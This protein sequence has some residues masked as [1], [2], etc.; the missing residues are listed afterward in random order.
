MGEAL[1]GKSIYGKYEDTNELPLLDACSAHYGNTPDSTDATI[2]HYHVQDAAPFVVGCFGPNEDASLVTV[3]QCRDF[4]TGP[5]KQ[6]SIYWL[7]NVLENT[8]EV[9]RRG[10]EHPISVLSGS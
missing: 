10:S 8:D 4:Y 7:R 2:Y 6:I 1:D 5:S 9:L 3:A